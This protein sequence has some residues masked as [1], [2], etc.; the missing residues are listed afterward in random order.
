MPGLLIPRGPTSS[1]T[2]VAYH[3]PTWRV[4]GTDRPSCR[5]TRAACGSARPQATSDA[6]RAIF[7]RDLKASI[8]CSTVSAHRAEALAH[9]QGFSRGLEPRDRPLRRQLR[10]AYTV[11]YGGLAAGVLPSC[12]TRAHA[13]RLIQAHVDMAF[14]AADPSLALVSQGESG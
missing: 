10:E 3:G 14:V 6:T 2:A 7:A 12:W 9:S 13:A 5:A 11:D 4:A 8:E 1:P